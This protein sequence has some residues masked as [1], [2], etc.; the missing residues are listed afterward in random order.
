M[1]ASTRSVSAGVATLESCQ[2]IIVAATPL[3]VRELSVSQS[4]AAKRSLAKTKLCRFNFAPTLPSGA[5]SRRARKRE[6]A[7]F[8]SKM[9]LIAFRSSEFLQEVNIRIKRTQPAYGQVTVD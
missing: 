2:L 9:A 7:T 8:R 3:P 4:V 1:G 5:F 6:R